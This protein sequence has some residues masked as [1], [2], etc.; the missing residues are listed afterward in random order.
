MEDTDSEIINNE[1]INLNSFDDLNEDQLKLLKKYNKKLKKYFGYETLKFEQF[2][3][4]YNVCHLQNDVCAILN[5]GFGKSINFQLSVVLYKKCVICISP[6]ISLMHE[7]NL[8]MIQK[9]IPVCCFNSDY[10]D[11]EKYKPALISNE[12]YRLIYMTP[13]YIIKSEQFLKQLENS[14]NLLFITIDESHCLSSWG[15]DFRCSYIQLKSIRDWIPNIP[16]LSLTATASTVVRNDIVNTLQLKNHIEIIGNFDRPNL[17]IAVHKK[18]N[19]ITNDLSGLLNQYK[20]NHII[21]YCKTRDEVDILTSELLKM[22]INCSSYHAGLTENARKTS[23]NNFIDGTCKCIVATIAFGMG[24][25]I[26]TVRLVIHYGCPKNIEGY[27]QEI[28]RAGRDGLYSECHLFFC[29]KDFSKNRYFISKI[30]DLSQ[31]NYQEEQIRQ[32]ES[33]VYAKECRRKLLLVNFGQTV[34]SCVACDNCLNL[35]KVEINNEDYTLQ[36]FLV[37]STINRIN[38]KFGC[39]MAIN[40]LLGMAT[41]IKDYMLNYDSFGNGKKY[42]NEKWWSEFFKS[43]VSN[44]YIVEKSVQGFFGSVIGLTEKGKQTYKNLQK[45]SLTYENLKSSVIPDENKILFEKIV[46]ETPIKKLTKK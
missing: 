17:Y 12:E 41:K 42:G 26:P 8:E 13:E 37:L 23:H 7:Q 20:N 38:D 16:I 18:S 40:I 32:I 27:Y 25:N 30:T 43:L 1:I 5:T 9:N 39:K 15:H 3:I 21:I 29:P 44:N 19:N 24:I 45:I 10:K 4:I 14:N 28:G 35:G 6:L 31:H 36:T 34:N 46:V 2:K 11:S 22:G 33:F